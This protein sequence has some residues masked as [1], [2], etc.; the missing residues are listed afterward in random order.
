MDYSTKQHDDLARP[1]RMTRWVKALVGAIGNM[2]AP[3]LMYDA[4]FRHLWD[5]QD[6]P[7]ESSTPTT[8]TPSYLTTMIPE[9][10]RHEMF[11]LMQEGN[12]N[13]REPPP[14]L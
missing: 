14:A 3:L 11:R 1:H 8:H 10:V 6:T 2:I 4:Y 9:S 12:P 13:R 7:D 5:M